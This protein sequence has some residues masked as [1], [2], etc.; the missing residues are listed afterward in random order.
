MGKRMEDLRKLSQQWENVWKLL[1][2][3]PNSGK[4]YGRPQ[5]TFP[6]RGKRTEDLRMLS[7]DT[8][9]KNKINARAK[10]KG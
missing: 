10:F 7:A 8:D 6:T 9:N 2:S 3:F 4:T 5:E 1:G